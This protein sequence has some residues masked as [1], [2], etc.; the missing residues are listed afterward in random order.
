MSVGTRCL[1]WTLISAV[2]GVSVEMVGQV[3][4]SV[5]M[6]CPLH[7]MQQHPTGLLVYW[8]LNDKDVVAAVVNGM[9]E[10][11]YQDPRYKGRTYLSPE[12]LKNG[13]FSL[14]LSNLSLSDQKI[15]DC[16]I[17]LELDDDMKD[18]GIT[19]IHLV[20]K[21]GFNIP[22]VTS[23]VT[24]K[25]K[26]GQEVT[27]TCRSHGGLFIPNVTW[28]NSTDGSPMYEGRI[29][30]MHEKHGTVI[31]VTSTMCLNVTS[32]YN[33]TC[34]VTDAQDNVTSLNYLLEIDTELDY[35]NETLR[36]VPKVVSV[37]L[38]SLL[39]IGVLLCAVIWLIKRN[40]CCNRYS[41]V[42]GNHVDQINC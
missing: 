25:V 1:F 41:G 23:S 16:I 11:K 33:V 13:N 29:H 17:M 10:D 12:G 39:L 32:T 38:V 20:V 19:S 37:S 42:N 34:R 6:P 24:G 36:Q 30:S 14:R 7:S 9:V 26:Y 27:M 4:D 21:A 35:S 31:S 2:S 3:G 18:L 8:Q 5:T 40:V 22:S 28:L 15:Y